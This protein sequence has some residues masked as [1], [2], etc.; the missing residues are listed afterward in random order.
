MVIREMEGKRAA[1]LL[2]RWSSTQRL[3]VGAIVGTVRSVGG[4]FVLDRGVSRPALDLDEGLL[5]RFREPPFFMRQ[6][7]ADAELLLSVGVSRLPA[8]ADF[9]I[10]FSFGFV[11]PCRN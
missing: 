10:P 9:V 8:D 2:L 6:L 3:D 5:E 7:F 4:Q 1:I 11:E